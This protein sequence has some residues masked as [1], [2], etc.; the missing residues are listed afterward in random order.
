[1]TGCHKWR[2]NENLKVDVWVI[3]IF[4]NSFTSLA[5]EWHIEVD[6]MGNVGA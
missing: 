2:K 4:K 6:L 1:M 5:Q 3:K